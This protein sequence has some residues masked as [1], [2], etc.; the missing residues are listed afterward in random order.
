MNNVIPITRATKIQPTEPDWNGPEDI[1]IGADKNGER[2]EATIDR[3]DDDQTVLII[4]PTT[5]TGRVGY[6]LT[7]KQAVELTSSLYASMDRATRNR[8]QDLMHTIEGD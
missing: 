3:N 8:F 1:T 6:T 5:L 2:L 7:D 4:P